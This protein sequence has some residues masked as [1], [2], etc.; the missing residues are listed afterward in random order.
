MSKA[1]AI[2]TS[3]SK[4]SKR[5]RAISRE[6]IFASIEAHARASQALAVAV[7]ALDRAEQRG[8][9]RTTINRANAV[10]KAKARAAFKAARAL[11]NTPIH[12]A[13]AAAA[14]LRY[15]RTI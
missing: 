1:V 14:L 5:A 12:S 15:V 13:A 8:G 7:A 6:P 2:P 11:C 3:Q 9:S 10:W 4:G